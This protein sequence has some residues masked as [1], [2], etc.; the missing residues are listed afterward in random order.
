MIYQPPAKSLAP[1]KAVLAPLQNKNADFEKVLATYLRA[2]DVVIGDAWVW[3]LA[4]GLRALGEGYSE[5]KIIL[6]AYSC[7]EFT[8]AIL[9]AGFEPL[10]IDLADD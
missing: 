9:L 2:K 1:L 6:P 4:E 3:V 7:N 8:K 5:K 10:Y